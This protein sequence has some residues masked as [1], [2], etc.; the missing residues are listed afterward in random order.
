META[1]PTECLWIRGFNQDFQTSPS[2]RSTS[3]RSP[4]RQRAKAMHRF[5]KQHPMN[6]KSQTNLKLQTRDKSLDTLIEPAASGKLK[7]AAL[8]LPVRPLI[9]KREIRINSVLNHIH[10]SHS[11]STRQQFHCNLCRNMQTNSP[12]EQRTWATIATRALVCI[13][14]TVAAR[15]VITATD[16]CC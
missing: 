3:G 7:R 15:A 5:H 1:S 2:G 12:E 8:A 13:T 11:N 4:I 6:L 16:T 9:L 14:A 10:P